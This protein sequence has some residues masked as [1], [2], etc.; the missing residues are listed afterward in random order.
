[1]D[2]RKAVWEQGT[3]CCRTIT[4]NRKTCGVKKYDKYIYQKY[5]GFEEFELFPCHA[6]V[7][8]VLGWD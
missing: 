3:Q 5:K 8:L 1:M 4:N 7:G 2:G 6:T